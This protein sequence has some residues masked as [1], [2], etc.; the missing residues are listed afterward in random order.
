[1]QPTLL[2]SPL[3]KRDRH[4]PATIL[5]DNFARA[6]EA[7]HLFQRAVGP[8]L[9]RAAYSGWRYMLKMCRHRFGEFVIFLPGIPVCFWQTGLPLQDGDTHLVRRHFDV[10]TASF[11][12]YTHPK[13]FPYAFSGLP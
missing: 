8:D 12:R 5:P 2:S 3:K 4:L 7:S 1:M 13:V 10:P 6:V 11:S 9:R